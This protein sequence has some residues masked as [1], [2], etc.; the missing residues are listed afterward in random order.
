MAKNF[1]NKFVLLEIIKTTITL[2]TLI[3]KNIT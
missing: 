3:R 1:P 2:I